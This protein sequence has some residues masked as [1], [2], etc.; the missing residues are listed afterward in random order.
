MTDAEIRDYLD[1][2]V[3]T[4]INASRPHRVI[5]IEHDYSDVDRTRVIVKPASGGYAGSIGWAT[6][7]GWDVG[8]MP[9]FA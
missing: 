9:E 1:S 3:G 6:A 8:H 5:R 4:T 7:H 2:L